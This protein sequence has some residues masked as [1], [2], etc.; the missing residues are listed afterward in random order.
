M[1][2]VGGEDPGGLSAQ[3]L[4][5]CWAVPARRWV[6]AR[7]AQ[8]LIDG[9]CRD[10]QAQLGQLAVNTPVTPERVFVRQAD[11]EPGDA[12]DRRRGGRVGDAYWC[13]ISWR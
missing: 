13:R 4:P 3:E 12:P 11:G 1:Q 5:P 10:G 6:D 2:E 9:R 7:G 8:D